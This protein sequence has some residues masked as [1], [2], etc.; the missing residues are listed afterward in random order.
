[1]LQ[2]AQVVGALSGA[3]NGSQ[4]TPKL[5][6]KSLTIILLGI[7]FAMAQRSL[8]GERTKRRGNALSTKWLTAKATSSPSCNA[9]PAHSLAIR[10]LGTQAAYSEF[11]AKLMFTS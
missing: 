10:A 1:M 6:S 9:S 3:A 5:W 2:V 8:D 11:S 7:V 4:S